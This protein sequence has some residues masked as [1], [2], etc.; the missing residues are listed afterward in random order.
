MSDPFIFVGQTIQ[1]FISDVPNKCG[2][3]AILRKEARSK[4]EVAKNADVFITTSVES[5]DP[6][7]PKQIPPPPNRASLVGAIQLSAQDQL[8][9][10]VA[11]VLGLLEKT[12]QRMIHFLE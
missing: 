8:L 11:M 2:W 5:T 7:A 9:A 4:R 10:M 6:T 12:Q 3:K 1:I